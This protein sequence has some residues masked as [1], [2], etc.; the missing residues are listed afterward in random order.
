M[1]QFVGTLVGTLPFRGMR[2]V[3]RPVGR[4]LFHRRTLHNVRA[5]TASPPPA[6]STFFI[7]T[8]LLRQWGPDASGT[9][10]PATVPPADILARV[11]AAH[12]AGAPLIDGYAPFCKHI[13][14]KAWF[15]CVPGV[16]TITDANRHLVRSGYSARR[17]EE[18]AVLSRWFDFDD[19]QHELKPA[20]WLD[21]ILYQNDQLA[22]EAAAL[23][24][25]E[26]APLPAGVPWG[27]ISI[28]AQ[29][30]DYELPMTPITAMRNALGR[31]HGGSGVPIDR[32]AYDAAVAYWS[33]KAAVVR[34]KGKGE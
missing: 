7:D 10:L 16:L 27:V 34:G 14:V 24:A 29:D 15:D 25:A 32:A 11:E 28:K 21:C 18:L 26:R 19:V 5:M 6:G 17:P 8:F 23:P 9:V 3:L 22:K 2:P 12:Q 31:E 4:A 33:D 13:F 1:F 20:T 30:E